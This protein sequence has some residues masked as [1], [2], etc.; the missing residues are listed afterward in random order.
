MARKRFQGKDRKMLNLLKR[1]FD[2]CEARDAI[3]ADLTKKSA[4]ISDRRLFFNPGDTQL[5]DAVILVRD[6]IN[7]QLNSTIF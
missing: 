1:L 4:A 6:T 2:A 5:R 7:Y 3:A